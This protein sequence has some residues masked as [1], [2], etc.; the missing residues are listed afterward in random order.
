[1]R[2]PDIITGGFPCQPVSLAGRRIGTA[3]AR[4]LWPEYA[5]AL[6]LL[7]P[8]YAIVENPTGLLS[9]GFGR[10]LGDLA[11]CGYDA[12]WDCI[13]AAAFGAPHL[14]YR[15]FIIAYSQGVRRARA[16][17]T[18]SRGIGF[19][20][21]D[22]SKNRWWPI[23]PGIRGVDDGIPNRVERLKALGNA[24]VPQVAE[25]IGRRIMEFEETL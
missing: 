5:R 1:M 15:A 23:D 11:S 17:G 9:L 20:N 16:G 3:D 7:R 2:R 14:R 24:V 4:W 19:E 12:E 8:R 10:V 18:R 22:I 13:P 25:W 21:G 6:R